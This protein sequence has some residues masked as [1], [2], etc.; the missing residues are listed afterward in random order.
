MDLSSG[1]LCLGRCYLTWGGDV[2]KIIEI[3]VEIVTYVVRGKTRRKL[4][5]STHRDLFAE[6]VK[7]EVPCDAR[8]E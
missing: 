6:Q 7:G 8:A 5:R 4:W 3:T 1:S 2:R